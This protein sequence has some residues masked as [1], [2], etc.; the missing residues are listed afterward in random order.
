ML[1]SL[2]QGRFGKSVAF[3]R[4][5]GHFKEKFLIYMILNCIFLNR[6]AFQLSMDSV[7]LVHFMKAQGDFVLK[8][9]RGALVKYILDV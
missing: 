2:G 1:T 6:F 3:T 9:S 4:G 5:L 7:D 8:C